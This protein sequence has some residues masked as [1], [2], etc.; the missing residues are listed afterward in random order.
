MT[1]EAFGRFLDCLT[2]ASGAAALLSAQS[3][4][5]GWFVVF[6]YVGTVMQIFHPAFVE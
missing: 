1:R 4:E 5:I 3:N 6:I 2:G